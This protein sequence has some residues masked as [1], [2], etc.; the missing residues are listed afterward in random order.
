MLHVPKLRPPR[1]F[2]LIR[3]AD[4]VSPA[5][6]IIWI[7][8]TITVTV[9]AH[10]HHHSGITLS[11]PTPDTFQLDLSIAPII[12]TVTGT[13]LED[14]RFSIR[15]VLPQGLAISRRSGV[16]SGTPTVVTAPTVYFIT[17]TSEEAHA[18]FALTLSVVSNSAPSGLQYSTPPPLL[19]GLPM[20]PLTPIVTGS[21]T[22]YSVNPALPPGLAINPSTGVI[23]G[24]PISITAAAVYTITAA[25]AAGETSFGLSLSVDS[26]PTVHL[27]AAAT[28]PNGKP[29]TFRWQTTDGTLANVS[30]AQADWQ[31][32]SG[33]GLHFAYL[34]ASN[35]Q[36]GYAEQRLVVN[37]DTIGN[38]VLA[39]APV[40]L[41]APPAPSQQGDYYRSYVQAGATASD[42]FPSL[43]AGTH[44]VYVAGIGVQILDTAHSFATVG[45]GN[46]NQRGEYVIQSLP[47][48][49]TYQA[50]CQNQTS[51]VGNLFCTS[52]SAFQSINNLNF[53]MLPLAITDWSP[54]GETFFWPWMVGSLKLADGNPCGLSEEF[55]GLSPAGAVT[56][57]DASNNPINAPQFSPLKVSEMMDFAMPTPG[58]FTSLGGTQLQFSCE[59]AAPITMPLPATSTSAN[60]DLGILLFPGT[61]APTITS[62]TAAY[63]GQ[64]IAS[65]PPPPPQTPPPP[66]PSN[67]NPRTT[68]FLG[69]KGVDSK[70]SACQYYKAIGAVQSCD[71]SG[72]PSGAVSFDDWMRGVKIGPYAVPGTTEFTAT[73]INK[74][75]L[76][77]AR[78][79]HSIS[80]G[81]NQTAAYVC[82]HVGPSVPD[83]LQSEID[84]VIDDA[85]NNRKLVA[86]VAMD[87]GVSPGV[88]LDSQG[89]AQ[90]FT[91]FLIF[92]PGG[93]L[94]PSVNLDGRGE[95]FV[96]GTC[97]ACHGGDH[98]AGH[99]PED[100]S[101]SAN[102]GAHFVPYDSGN[103][104]FS[105]KPGLTLADQ[106]EVIY[107]LNQNVLNA[108]PTVAEQ[109]LITGWY[110][111]SHVLDPNYL[112]TSWQ[113]A[114]P[115]M[116]NY[117]HSIYAHSCRT[118]HVA[119][120]EGYNFDHFPNYQVPNGTYRSTTGVAPTVTAQC[121][122]G[123]ELP[124]LA[125]SMPNSLVTFNRFWGQFGAPNSTAARIACNNAVNP[126]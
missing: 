65:F 105:S 126:F 60:T 43:G 56:L 62:M 90:P 101:G 125:Y 124:L 3:L 67:I 66:P 123:F 22:L 20:S 27:S 83:P 19:V 95:K 122:P 24:T 116:I 86:C 50:D 109:E 54:G 12:P 78:V 51:L 77:L 4:I 2:S 75:D 38:P 113:T 25:N 31:L 114:S 6:W 44:T 36:G 46:T 5:L 58:G 87:Y 21:V 88:N 118:C 119:M 82:N 13:E 108:G 103:F 49:T 37:T 76:N 81:P 57:L 74:V 111:T 34:L 115:N 8:L 117:Y 102:I 47:V 55:F 32:P 63:Q 89:V 120:T 52:D 112:P 29:L 98:Y 23:S 45:S 91:R 28:D 35:G 10:R 48:G 16:I 84:S 96:P 17:A 69:F 59:G 100:G 33:P 79:H 68:A 80:Y 92:G 107:L 99:F 18:T 42:Y 93:N 53:A 15:P 7:A 61:G 110:T 70:K 94:L 30:G 121:G 97:V 73:Y 64:V 39:T 1:I 72:T 41:S 40:T 71:A 26:G 14:V 104:E 9:S 85:V 106:Q 11:Y